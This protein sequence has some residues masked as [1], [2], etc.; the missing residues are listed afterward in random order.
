MFNYMLKSLPAKYVFA[1]YSVRKSL[2]IMTTEI[3]GRVVYDVFLFTYV[4]NYLSF[5]ILMDN[6]KYRN[7]ETKAEV[8]EASAEDL[9]SKHI[10]RGM[11]INP[12][13]Y[14]EYDKE[15]IVGVFGI[16]DME[17]L[18]KQ[19]DKMHSADIKGTE[20]K[21]EAM[22][23]IKPQYT[24]ME[25]SGMINMFNKALKVEKG[26]ITIPPITYG[27]N[28]QYKSLI[29]DEMDYFDFMSNK[30][31]DTIVRDLKKLDDSLDGVGNLKDGKNVV[32]TKR[33]DGEEVTVDVNVTDENQE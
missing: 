29:G 1:G 8:P 13:D 31:S 16:R 22:L 28:D 15:K 33:M 6:G 25:I 18:M 23:D 4:D 5:Y 24:G 14:D 9:M 2:T 3:N 21:M 11:L 7:V 32:L 12:E 20:I 26:R 27:A 19:V 10:A 30:D 17:T